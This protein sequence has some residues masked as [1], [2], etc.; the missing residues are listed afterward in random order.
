[1]GG[2]INSRTP[3]DGMGYVV[4]MLAI[5]YASIAAWAW[6]LIIAIFAPLAALGTAR[7]RDLEF[8]AELFIK[9]TWFWMIFLGAMLLPAALSS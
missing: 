6:M 9:S 8:E 2:S 4:F 7:N 1:M 3:P 5:T